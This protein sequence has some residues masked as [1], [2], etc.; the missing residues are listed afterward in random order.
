VLT[1]T[2]VPLGIVPAGS[3]N[4]HARTYGIPRRSAEKAAD[5]IADGHRTTVD[6]GRIVAAD[7]ETRYF[8]TVVAAGFDSLVNDRANRMRRPRGRMRYNL[9]TVVE[10]ANLRRVPFRVEV[11]D[12]RFNQDLVLAAVGNAPTYGG[13]MRIC[14]EADAADGLLDV[15]VVRAM[16]RRRLVRFFPSVYTGTL[17]RHHEVE[18]YRAATVRLDARGIRAYADGELVGSLPVEVTV[19]PRALRILTPAA[20]RT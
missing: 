7:G 13:G 15:T 18:M 16:P 8:G 4:D 19:V 9:A 14:P 1:G 17:A 3:G 12:D 2:E 11:D 6:I 20:S 10:L 5:V